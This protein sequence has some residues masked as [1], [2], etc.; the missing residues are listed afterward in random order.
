MNLPI[1]ALLLA[2]GLGTRLRPLTNHTPKCL[3]PIA[4]KPLLARW[5]EQLESLSCQAAMVNTHYLAEQVVAFLKKRQ[6]GD[7]S[8]KH[9]YEP[10]LL[11]T[12][13]T[14]L[15][16]QSFFAGCTGILIHADNATDTDLR[17]LIKAH[18]ERPSHCLLT[19][20]TFSTKTPSQCGIVGIDSDGVV[21]AFHEK[22]SN[23][24]GNRANGAVYVFDQELIE[25]LV[26][27]GPRISDFSTHVLPALVGRIQTCHTS[28]QYLDIGTP[29]GLLEAQ[30]IWPSE[31]HN[32]DD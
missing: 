7:M 30:T 14:L 24:P 11:G 27:L 20:L 31:H 32:Q 2:A 10:E 19:M 17:C 4:G 9:V 21:K 16:N 5:L 18:R 22:A 15:A 29:D 25:E 1:R 12:A 23:P 28:A 26:E 6:A 13:G 8:V 3:V